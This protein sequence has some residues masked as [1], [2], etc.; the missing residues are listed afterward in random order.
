M[1]EHDVIAYSRDG[2]EDRPI[3]ELVSGVGRDM[4]LLVRQEIHL[5]KIEIGEKV[6]HVTKGAVSIGIGGV[7]AYAGALALVAALV[8]VAI[9]I[10]ITAWLAAALI[11]V[12]L[13]VAGF[14][15]IGAG[16]RNITSGPPPLQRT[17]D[18]AKETIVHLKEQLR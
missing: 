14:A 8:L 5:A 2:L 4:G 7:L 10:G 13:L 12:I 6:A 18:N 15:T 16:K 9:A 1:R 17:K 11:G 3:T